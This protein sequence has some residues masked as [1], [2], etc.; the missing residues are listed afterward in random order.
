MRLIIIDG[1]DGVGKDTHSRLIADRYSKKGENVFIRSHPESDNFFGRKAKKALLGHGKINRL[2]ASVF[3]MIDV[4]R[5]IRK[6][7]RRKDIDTLIMTRY[8]VGTA[9][10]P[11]KLAKF[12]YNFFVKFVPTSKYMFFLDA[13]S[14]EL[15][16]RIKDRKKREMFEKRSEFE[17]VRRKALILVKNWSIIDASGSVKDTFS[18]IE[19][20][21]N[22]SD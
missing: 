20:L 2:K 7:Y 12:A 13:P 15:L 10:L 16:K 1:L 21:L 9:Y 11:K 5:S 22:K 14:S 4:L 6:Y 19:I 3:Y 17:K 8:L 18:Q